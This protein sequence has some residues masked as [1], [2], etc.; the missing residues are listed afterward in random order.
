MSVRRRPESADVLTPLERRVRDLAR[1]ARVQPV[2][3]PPP[4]YRRPPD[5][6]LEDQRPGETPQQ[7]WTRLRLRLDHLGRLEAG[8]RYL[9]HLDRCRYNRR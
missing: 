6:M 4:L 9:A 8:D 5:S 1:W 3:D 2:T 7:A